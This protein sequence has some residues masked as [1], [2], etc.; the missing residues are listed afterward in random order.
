M[1]FPGLLASM[2]ITKAD[3]LTG[4]YKLV[5]LESSFPFSRGRDKDPFH[6]YPLQKDSLK[7][8]SEEEELAFN[9]TFK[10]MPWP[11]A[12]SNLYDYYI[13]EKDLPGAGIVMEALVLEHPTEPAFY[14]NAANIFG[15]LKEND[16]A[17]FY[18]KKAFALSPSFDK[19]SHLFVLDLKLDRPADALPY[20]DYAIQNNSSGANLSSVKQYAE[21]IVQWQ[22]LVKKDPAD[23][24][25]I[26]RIAEAYSKMGNKD[27]ADK[28]AKILLDLTSK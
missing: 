15:E 28:Y 13:R 27:A 18:F 7:I 11:E 21:Q 23:P 22:K 14:E 8:A 9:I 20:L 12:M 2:P 3:S 4:V 26:S 24:S 17:L 6:S 1:P 16:K 10:H 25:V 5:N 19:A